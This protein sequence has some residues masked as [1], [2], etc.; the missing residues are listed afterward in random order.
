MSICDTPTMNCW[1]LVCSLWIKINLNGRWVESTS[2][3]LTTVEQTQQTS[4]AHN[5]SVAESSGNSRHI[6]DNFLD[7]ASTSHSSFS[8]VFRC[9][10]RV[11]SVFA[12]KKWRWLTCAWRAVCAVRSGTAPRGG[13]CQ[14]GSACGRWGRRGGGLPEQQ[15]STDRVIE[16]VQER[17]ADFKKRKKKKQVWLW[18]KERVNFKG[19]LGPCNKSNGNLRASWALSCNILAL[20]HGRSGI[21][22]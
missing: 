17:R 6:I 7:S 4:Q 8:S 5:W 20:S 10:N 9:L 11:F 3:Y 22:K 18:K 13:A 2:L 12:K 16:W 14:S 15:K 21:N 1:W 19:N